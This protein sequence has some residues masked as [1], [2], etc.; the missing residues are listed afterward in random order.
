MERTF[1]PG[2]R[3]SWMD[4]TILAIGAAGAVAVG[5]VDGWIGLAIAFVVG[6]FFLFCNVLRMSRP[7]EL[8]W[9][10]AFA[11]LALGAAVTEAISW[12]MVFVV[13]TG[14]TVVLAVNEM[15]RPCYHGVGWQRVNPR[16]PGWWE[17]ENAGPA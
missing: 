7:P 1:S 10:V 16:L 15:R 6:H 4:V 11:L 5:T 14:L 17:A 9:A 12:P 13:S 2:F 3:L 8:I